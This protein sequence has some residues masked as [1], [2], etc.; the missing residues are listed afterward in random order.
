[1]GLPF[2]FGSSRAPAAALVGSVDDSG[3]NPC[4]DVVNGTTI[5][6]HHNGNFLH[7]QRP[8]VSV[9]ACARI[10][11]NYAEPGKTCNAYS[12]HQYY[13][14]LEGIEDEWFSMACFLFSDEQINRIDNIYYTS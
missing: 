5:E 7:H 12:W 9:K 1:M 8:V 13:E 10:C 4:G 3:P 6:D 2:G 14:K 11:L